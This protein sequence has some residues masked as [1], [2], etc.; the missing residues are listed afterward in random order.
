[1]IKEF[2]RRNLPH[3]TPLRA[4]F[5]VTYCLADA[6]PQAMLE[7]MAEEFIMQVNQLKK[8]PNF[9]PSMLSDLH[10]KQ[11]AKYDECLNKGYGEQYLKKPEIAEIVKNSLHYFDDSRLELISYCIMSNHVHVMFRLFEK[12]KLDKPITL[13]KIMHSIKSF[14]GS[15]INYKL[16]RTGTLWQAESY[17]HWVRHKNSWNRIVDYI[18]DNPVKAGLVEDRKDWKWSYIKEDYNEFM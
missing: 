11:F 1:M 2:Y 9:T 8:E 10:K 15:E 4:T 16:K 5:F 17:D 13:S 3:W 18:L 14:S 7:K 6:I 12:D